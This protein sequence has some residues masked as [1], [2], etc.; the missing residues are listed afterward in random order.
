VEAAALR[1]VLEDRCAH[2]LAH[3]RRQPPRQFPKLLWQAVSLSSMLSTVLSHLLVFLFLLV[4]QN[5][6]DLGITIFT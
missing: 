2:I 1:V 6:F 4:V 5:R 3:S